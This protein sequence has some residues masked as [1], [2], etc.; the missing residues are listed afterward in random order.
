[1][2]NCYL[3]NHPTEALWDT[4]AQSSV[5]ND[6]WR[7]QHLPHTTIRPIKELLGEE[8]LTVHAANNTPILYLGWIEVN[9][10]LAG[11]PHAVT[12]LRIP[13]LVSSDP[14][15]ADDPIIGYNVIETVIQQEGGRAT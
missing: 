8:N 15:V 3:D 1:M 12:E 2:V 6:H 10:T 5:I 13:L 14:A 9:F 11:G 4:G 7:Q